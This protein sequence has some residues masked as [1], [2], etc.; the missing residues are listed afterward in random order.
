MRRIG[1]SALEPLGAA[2]TRRCAADC[3]PDCDASGVEREPHRLEMLARL[4]ARFGT[5]E[6][7]AEG[8][9]LL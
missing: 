7:G 5:E 1:L 6:G 8:A 3:E 9:A 4:L 2:L